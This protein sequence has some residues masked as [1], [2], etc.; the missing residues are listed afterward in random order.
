MMVFSLF[1]DIFFQT[2]FLNRWFGRLDASVGSERGKN[3]GFRMFQVSLDRFGFLQMFLL[4]SHIVNRHHYGKNMQH[5]HHQE[6]KPLVIPSE[7]AGATYQEQSHPG[8]EGGGESF[9]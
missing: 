6:A 1:S 4:E 5:L 7:G 9:T 2:T 8:G 3:L